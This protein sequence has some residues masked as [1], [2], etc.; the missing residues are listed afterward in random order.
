MFGVPAL[1]AFAIGWMIMSRFIPI[2]ERDRRTTVTI[3][4]LLTVT[5]ALLIHLAFPEEPPLSY[6][7]PMLWVGFAAPRLLI[8]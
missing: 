2:L 7:V 3:L 6:L 5:A 4:S 8:R 1:V